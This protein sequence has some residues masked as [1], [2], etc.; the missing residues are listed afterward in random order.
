[1]I[2]VIL[3][4]LILVGVSFYLLQLFRYPENK[5]ILGASLIISIGSILVLPFFDPIKMQGFLAAL[6]TEESAPSIYGIIVGLIVSNFSIYSIHILA[7]SI[8][9]K[10]GERFQEGVISI[11]QY[12][13]RRH[14]ILISSFVLML[15]Y[16]IVMGSI[17]GI[18]VLTLVL[19]FLPIIAKKKEE[20]ELIP[21]YGRSYESYQEKVPKML[22][23][24]DV[25]GILII[26]YALFFIGLF[27]IIFLAEL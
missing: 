26:Y 5:G 11:G 4:I 7:S 22:F 18:V 23:S 1:M 13:R 21:K 9:L 12:S 3:I 10:R 24:L 14:P 27:G 15:S 25:L 2:F 16:Q 20:K 17:A 8:I 6:F 19:C